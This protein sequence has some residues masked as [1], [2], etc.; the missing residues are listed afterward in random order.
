M[1]S[2][3]AQEHAPVTKPAKSKYFARYSVA[4]I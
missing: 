1:I 4:I 3:L 2:Q